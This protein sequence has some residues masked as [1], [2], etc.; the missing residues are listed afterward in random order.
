MSGVWIPMW[1]CNSAAAVGVID[2]V[3]R[4][5]KHTL[6]LLDLSISINP[7]IQVCFPVF[8]TIKYPDVIPT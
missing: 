7:T 8:I 2:I 4:T 1:V 3:I 6:K 5:G